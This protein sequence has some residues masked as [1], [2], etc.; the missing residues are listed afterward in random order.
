[1]CVSAEGGRAGPKENPWDIPL[2]EIDR[3][4]RAFSRFLGSLAQFDRDIL[5]MIHE[6]L[7]GLKVG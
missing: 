7:T 3:S 4:R 1:M 2:H 6:K 5:L